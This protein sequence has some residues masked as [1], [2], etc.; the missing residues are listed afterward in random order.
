[1]RVLACGDREWTNSNLIAETLGDLPFD[2][3]IEGEQRG[4]DRL[5]R[6][7]ARS[8]GRHFIPYPANWTRYGRAAG[9]IR[10]KQMLD[11]GKPDLVVAFHNHIEES[12]G[13]ANML[14]QA[15][16]AGVPYC[17]ITE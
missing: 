13:T 5:A 12:K 14:C 10:N 4:A 11:S 8:W 3:I 9:P 17:L 1:M 16:D 7:F 15:E 2:T 6:E